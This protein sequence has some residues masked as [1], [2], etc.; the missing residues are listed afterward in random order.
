[1]STGSATRPVHVPVVVEQEHEETLLHLN[2]P[3]GGPP[4]PQS[5]EPPISNAKMGMLML[6]G[7]ETMFFA[8]LIGAYLV[9]RFGTTVWPS[10]HLYLPVAV[11]W[12]NS[13]I[14]VGS[15]YTMYKAT[16]HFKLANQE[17]FL[18]FLWATVCL[19]TIFLC[20]QG[21]EWIQLVHDGLTISAGMY[22]ATFYVLIGCHAL[23]VLAAV[24]WLTIVLFRARR[25]KYSQEQYTGIET[26]SMYWYYVGAVW[27]VLFPLVYLN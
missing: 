3:G 10:A 7:A 24:V 20:V 27:L 22:G 18:S 11:T 16:D 4:R 17:A 6:I 12:A 13:V 19:G 15:C 1:M 23:H 2:R 14:L 21:Y 9:F 5:G 8:G 25:G 26:C